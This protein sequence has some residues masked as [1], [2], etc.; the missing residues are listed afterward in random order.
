MFVLGKCFQHSSLLCAFKRYE[1]NEMLF[2]NA[3]PTG[4]YKAA[5]IRHLTDV[6]S[7]MLLQCDY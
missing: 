2:V 5:P 4:V 3:S 6:C 7:K 1:E